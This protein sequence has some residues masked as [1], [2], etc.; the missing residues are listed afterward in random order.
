[1]HGRAPG[2]ALVFHA[3][4]DAR[5]RADVCYAQIGTKVGAS[6]LYRYA[7]LFGFGQPT[8]IALTGRD[9]GTDPES[10]A[11]VGALARHDLD[12]AEVTATPLQILMAYCPWPTEAFCSGRARV[13]LNERERRDREAFPRRARP[14][15]HLSETADTFAPSCA[16][17]VVMAREGSGASL[18]RG[19]RE[20]R[21]GESR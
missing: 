16:D 8:R 11:V 6:T 13:A 20:D 5:S 4:R 7:R 9:L 2:D 18:V 14:P 12:R 21:H 17:A 19:R 15:R 3:R 1:M 10:L